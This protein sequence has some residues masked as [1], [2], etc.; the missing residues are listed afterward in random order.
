MARTTLV[1]VVATLA[2]LAVVLSGCGGGNVVAPANEVQ[3]QSVKSIY[4]QPFTDS[5]SQTP[6]WMDIA[7]YLYATTFN[8]SYQYPSSK[9]LL[10]YTTAQTPLQFGVNAPTHGLKPNFCYQMKIQGPAVAWPSSSPQTTD[11]T[12]YTLGYNGRWWDDTKNIPLADTDISAGTYVGDVIRGY[13]YFDFAVTASD[14]S[15]NQTSTVQNSYHV[16]WKTSDRARTANDGPIK[17]CSVVARKDGWA[18]NSN[19]TTATVKLYGEWEP[20][21]ALP[22]KLALPKGTYSGVEF[23]LTEESFHNLTG[24]PVGG[25]WRTVMTA[26]VPNFTLQ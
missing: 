26:S 22:G 23:R 2:V 10:T 17:N 21:R 1:A 5:A 14:G 6:R 3:P 11:F 19:H 12:N 7:N 4:L 24:S 8:S 18:Y 15:I 20:G 9:V 13:M 16:T 25:A